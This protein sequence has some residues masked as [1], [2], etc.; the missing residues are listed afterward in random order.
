MTKE[1]QRD[2]E[3][4]DRSPTVRLRGR[5]IDRTLAPRSRGRDDSGAVIVLAL[6]YILVVSLTVGALIT[7]VM[8]DLTN[9]SHFQDASSLRYAATSATDAAIQSIRYNPIPTSSPTQ[10]VA[11]PASYCWT[12]YTV[13]NGSTDV[14]EL[15]I[16]GYTI[17]VWCSTTEYLASSDTRDVMIYACQVSAE[18]TG[19]AC[20]N[21]TLLTAEV[22]IDD[23]P[24]GG[25][26]TFTAQCNQL[27]D[28]CGAGTTLEN[29]IWGTSSGSSFVAASPQTVAFYN[30]SYTTTITSAS[31][32]FGSQVYQLYARGS[33]GGSI[34]Y[35]SLSSSVCTVDAVGTV[36]LVSAGTCSLTADAAVT[37]GY[38]DSGP[39]TFTLT[40]NSTPTTAVVTSSSQ[41]FNR[42]PAGHLYGDRFSERPIHRNTHWKRGIL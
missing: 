10:G 23:Y 37:P 17:G 22:A 1:L 34:T 30:S 16:D 11:T 19:A 18:P 27:G 36:T 9:T 25:G 31:I 7:W 5:R 26:P 35:G 39:V 40:I 42:R 33:G 3:S 6:I 12:P 21:Q 41:S 14:S 28:S 20:E 8:N 38:Q 13:I 15:S 4:N 32:T 2:G 24:A 29:W